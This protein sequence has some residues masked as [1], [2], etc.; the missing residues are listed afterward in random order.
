MG[1]SQPARLRPEPLDRTG[2]L[3]R[4]EATFRSVALPADLPDEPTATWE[5]VM[6]AQ[7]GDNDG[8]NA[9]A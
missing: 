7:R 4:A 9:T 1:A 3:L 6:E 5:V 8:G 2:C